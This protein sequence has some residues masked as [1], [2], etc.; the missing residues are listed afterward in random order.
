MLDFFWL[1]L[2]LCFPLISRPFLEATDEETKVGGRGIVICHATWQR[3]RISL[4]HSHHRHQTA[5]WY[6]WFENGNYDS[7]SNNRLN[8]CCPPLIPLESGFPGSCCGDNDNVS[9]PALRMKGDTGVSIV[10]RR[11]IW[12]QSMLKLRWILLP[13]RLIPFS[14]KRCNKDVYF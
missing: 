5:R 7:V 12:N 1:R 4:S 6:W 10:I 8:R 2:P 14:L 3:N 11:L 9:G 13:S